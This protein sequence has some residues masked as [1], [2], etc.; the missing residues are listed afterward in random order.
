MAEEEKRKTTFRGTPIE[1][2]AWLRRFFDIMRIFLGIEG[3]DEAL[4]K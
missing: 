3:D 2:E 4:E 1:C